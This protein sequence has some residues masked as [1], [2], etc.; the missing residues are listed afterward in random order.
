MPIALQTQIPRGGRD[1]CR[2]IPINQ[3]FE[4]KIPY[5]GST[6]HT[7]WSTLNC[8]HTCICICT[9]VWACVYPCVCMRAHLCISVQPPTISLHVVSC[10]DHPVKTQGC[11]LATAPWFLQPLYRHSAILR[12]PILRELDMESCSV[13]L[14]KPQFLHLA[15]CPRYIQVPICMSS[16]LLANCEGRL[17]HGH[18]NHGLCYCLFTHGWMFLFRGI[19]NNVAT[20][21]NILH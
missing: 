19:M 6:F 18:T 14:S 12:R 1:I 9:C 2:V 15:C 16:W 11:S 13:Q 10:D 5:C 17:H 21:I 4:H 7:A 3:G 8:N 20:I